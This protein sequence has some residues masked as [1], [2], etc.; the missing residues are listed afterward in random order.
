MGWDR[1]KTQVI[2]V[3][4]QLNPPWCEHIIENNE[5]LYLINTMILRSPGS[6]FIAV[7]KSKRGIN[8][9]QVEGDTNIKTWDELKTQFRD[10]KMF[11]VT[12]TSD[13]KF[14]RV[15]VN[16]SAGFR[17][18]R[19]EQFESRFGKPDEYADLVRTCMAEAAINA[20]RYYGI[21]DDN[22]EDLSYETAREKCDLNGIGNNISIDTVRKFLLLYGFTH[23]RSLNQF[24][25]HKKKGPKKNVFAETQGV[26]FVL[27]SYCAEDEY[28]WEASDDDRHVFLFC[29]RERFL[30]DAYGCMKF[31][32][33]EG[34]DKAK[35]KH[36]MKEFLG[37]DVKYT[38]R[39][40]WRIKQ[41]EN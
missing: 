13:S 7:T 36:V 14:V 4:D 31:T 41:M 23:S 17:P 3:P 21:K 12:L 19:Q 30:V 40:V 25:S 9:Y 28:D 22:G 8:N 6:E 38:I 15:L 1:K 5:K 34:Q 33:E 39:N 16:S 37:K 27:V 35:M 24:K 11:L 26:Y 29:A 20:L 10:H 32:P 18:M 2:Y